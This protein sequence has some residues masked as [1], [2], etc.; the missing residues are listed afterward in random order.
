MGL[1]AV[2]RV[3]ADHAPEAQSLDRYQGL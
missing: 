2:L 1:N 3:L